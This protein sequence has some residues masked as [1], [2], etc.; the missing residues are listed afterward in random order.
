MNVQQQLQ[1]LK[2]THEERML[3]AQENIRKDY[4][5]LR[6]TI[7]EGFMKNEA[8]S[9]KVNNDA[10]FPKTKDQKFT[11]LVMLGKYPYDDLEYSEYNILQHLKQG[12]TDFYLS[13]IKC[14]I[15]VSIRS[16]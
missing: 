10:E 13:Q 11:R 3:A 9:P 5:S 8:E 1:L 16:I 2:K 6:D 14:D 7:V 4:E 12:E 15:G